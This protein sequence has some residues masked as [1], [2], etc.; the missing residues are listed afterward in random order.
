[1]ATEKNF[2]LSY[3][4]DEMKRR[5][6]EAPERSSAYSTS[7]SLAILKALR[8]THPQAA[9]LTALARAAKVKVGPCQEILDHLQDEGLVEIQPDHETGNDLA[10]LTQKGMDLT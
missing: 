8:D 7:A 4:F 5:E 3:L 1:M 9:S 6:G 10:R 2:S